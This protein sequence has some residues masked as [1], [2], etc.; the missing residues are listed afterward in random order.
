MVQV[1][2]YKTVDLIAY[3]K[4]ILEDSRPYTRLK[5]MIV[6]VQGIGKT[7][8]LQQLRL[9]GVVSRQAHPNDSWSRRMSRSTNGEKTAKGANISTVGVDISEWTFEPKKGKGEVSFGPLT[10]RTWDFGGQREYYAT[11]QYFLS[12][13]S[14]YIVVWKSTD[15]EAAIPDVHQ[16]LI[17]IQARAPN[18]PVIIV[19][20]HIDQILANLDR[21]PPNYLEELHNLI[22]EQFVMV[23][24]A[25]KKGL[26]RVVDA[27]FV[28]TKTRHNIRLLCNL[29][30]RTAFDIH[31][32]GSKERLLDQKIPA[33]YLAFEKIVVN[34]SDERR[35]LGIEPVM[36]AND[37]RNIV[38]ERML[39]NYGRAFRDD[40]EF[41]HAC[42]FLHENGVLLHY[43]DVNLR[44]L[45]FLDP[46]WLCDVLAHVITIR[47]INP[48]ARNGLMKI[49]DLHVL[50]K[51]LKLGNSAINLKSHIIS[52][53]HKF[54]VALTW[55]S[56]SLLIPSLLPDEYQLRGGYS[57]C[58]VTVPAKISH[59]VFDEGQTSYETSS[60]L[61]GRVNAQSFF[62]QKNIIE[63]SVP[64]VKKHPPLQPVK[65]KNQAAAS[66]QGAISVVNCDKGVG[67][68]SLA[69]ELTIIKEKIVRRLYA[70][71]YIPSGF[72]SR[73]M[74]RILGDDHIISCIERLFTVTELA[75]EY[76]LKDLNTVCSSNLKVEWLLWQT[77]IEL[78]I[79]D[80]PVFSLR[81]FL[82]FAEVRDVHYE[83]VEWRLRSEDGGAWRTVDMQHA[84][85]IE[86]VLPEF[87]LSVVD[88]GRESLL[89]SNKYCITR[90]LALIVDIIDTL[91][92]DWYPSLGTRFVH[93]SEGRLLVNRLIPCPMCADLAH[94][95]AST[96]RDDDSLPSKTFPSKSQLYCHRSQTVSNFPMESPSRTDRTVL[97][98]FSIEECILSA[99]EGCDQRCPRHGQVSLIKLAPDSSFL[100]IF[101]SY[102]IAPQAVKSGK[103]IG[104]GAFGF[105]FKA[106]VKL[107]DQTVVDAALK[108]L[109]PVEPGLGARGT[110]ISAYKAARVKWQRDPLQ[111]ACRA[112][113][114]CRQE[115]NVLLSLQHSNIT[116]LIGVCPR[117]LALVI[118]LAPLG[119]LNNLLSNYRRSGARLHLS[120]IQDT[121]NQVARAL[122]YLHEHRVI[123]RDLKCENVLVWRF[124]PP[125]SAIND[126]VVKLG[127]Y[128]ISRSTF[129]SGGAKGFGG[130]EGFMAPEIMR[131]NGEQ[132]YTEK[133]DC[134]SF[135][136]FLYELISLKLPFDGHEQVKEYILDGGRPRLTPSEL[137]YPC[138]VLDVMVVCWATQ[139]IDRPSASQLVSM[140]TAPEFTHLLDVISL[141][142]ADSSIH[143]TLSFPTVDEN[144]SLTAYYEDNVEGEIWL[145]RS[146]GSITVLG[147][148]QYGWL[149]SKSIDIGIED[150]VITAMCIVNDTVWMAE[151]TGLIRI[152]CRNSY[153]E[154][155]SFSIVRYLPDAL[156]CV[157][158]H[159]LQ[160]VSSNLVLCSLP[161]LLLI[162]R[163]DRPEDNFLV[164]T[165]TLTHISYK[166]IIVCCAS[167]KKQIW[168]GQDDGLIAIYYL[169]CENQ[170]ITCSSVNHSSKLD[171]KK[172]GKVFH[173]VTSQA[174]QALV[175][176][177][178]S[179]GSKVYQ[180]SCSEKA[181]KMN[182]D[183][184]KIL[185]SSESISTLD[186]EAARE[187]EVTALCLLDKTDGAQLYVGTNKGVI[188]VVQAL[189]M[190]PLAAFRPYLEHVHSLIALD[191]SASYLETISCRRSATANGGNSSVISGTSIG[192]I[193]SSI[194]GISAGAGGPADLLETVSW[195]KD[196]VSE[197]VSRFRLLSND[198]SPVS[199]SY[200]IS[201]GDGYR[202]LIDRFTDRKRQQCMSPRRESHCAIIWRTE[203]WI[204]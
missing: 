6:G 150:T 56:R 95:P 16:W 68:D 159:S 143:S 54:E 115:L 177:A 125:F 134:F 48:F 169:N 55:Q 13:R 57:G 104:R 118:E 142:D 112:Y 79:L 101:Q 58:R 175:W 35:S 33:S 187:G 124:P 188:I 186:I 34:I 18:S 24:D 152:I 37:F 45:Y 90:L 178:L 168:I 36:N 63:K 17:N 76:S 50:F 49:D 192:G 113:C 72:W 106:T 98:A 114:T 86:I 138:N 59:W 144:D 123:Y 84:T 158:V 140:T 8:L 47:E 29:L 80:Q 201:V 23:P 196:R 111:N 91:L 132:E 105:V 137:L 202:C 88:S 51:T 171:G 185:P 193:P 141:N 203:D 172:A 93:T 195:M 170:L 197:T 102:L 40:V 65:A 149:D 131:Y 176:T 25:D 103:M 11:H 151:S 107:K 42:S 116:A 117:P 4:S 180:W 162:L 73:L 77:G 69:L 179:P 108:M 204:A 87:K 146:D 83:Q 156:F 164:S 147:C 71:A 70:V 7:S 31:S 3:L 81:Q 153:A 27:I 38:R 15:G 148:N 9:E 85:I 75:A 74:T 41:N 120:V 163:A 174:E 130:T 161:S 182:L 135:A 62:Y 46:Q 154:V 44:D 61:S 52:L 110:S 127:D 128:G 173:M 14:L 97:Y 21:F 126:V 183:T 82:P 39:K 181:I 53:L 160:T 28:S 78:L 190:R 60:F 99:H 67:A 121:A 100:D 129:P 145:S 96:V 64:K 1:N 2:N 43:E 167:A 89:N 139:P 119:S 199:S 165:A 200:I 19:G 166:S 198:S 10:F 109:E 122:E 12:K 66:D 191:T 32:A 184:C 26:P 136:M 5:L 133:V 155:S 92:E 189:Q 22:R 20:T 30:Y 157:S 94:F 194:G